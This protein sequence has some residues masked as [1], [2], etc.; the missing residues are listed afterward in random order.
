R[1]TPGRVFTIA[2]LA[3][4]P[5]IATPAKA[6]GVGAAAAAHGVTLAKSTALASLLATL[7]GL[8]GP[9]L[10]LRANLDQARTPRE[11][12]LV[13]IVTCTFFFGALIFLGMLWGLREA[14]FRWWDHRI[15]FA[16]LAQALIAS[17]VVVWP[18]ALW[19]ATR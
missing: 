17:F 6:V 12:R 3:A 16:V 8:I 1:T 10:I 11:R 2:V 7:N 15:A 4:L 14:S 19:R 5:E 18:V 13:V 9:I